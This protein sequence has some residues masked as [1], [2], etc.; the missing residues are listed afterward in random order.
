VNILM[1]YPKYPDQTFWNLD[2]VSKR[3]YGRRATMA[4]LGLLTIASYLPDDFVVRLVDRNIREE[5]DD[6]WTWADAVLIS[7]MLAQRQDCGTCL[8]NA[9]RHGVPVAVGGPYTS[10]H[11]DDIVA[12]ADWVCYGEAESVMEEFVADLRAGRRKRQYRGGN[13]TDTKTVRVP[14][15][16]LLEN[17]N[18][19]YVMPV[20]FS[21]GCPFQCEFCDIIEIYGR[22]PRVK[23]PQQILAELDAIFA[24]RFTGCVFI[25]DDNFIGNKKA[26][27][28]MLV[29]LAEWNRLHGLPYLY[30]TEASLNLAGDIRLLDAMARANFLFVFVGIETPDAALLTRAGKSQNTRADAL[31]QLQTIREHGI[32]VI[33]GMITGFDG[34][35]RD[36]F[37]KQLAFIEKSG[38]G[39]A[40]PG[41]LQAVPNTRLWR[42]L[43]RENRL[44]ESFS[45]SLNV[46]LEGLNFIPSGEM[47]KREYLESMGRMAVDMFRPEAFFRRIVPAHLALRKQI[48]P[49]LRWDYLLT[50]LRLCAALGFATKETRIPFW[51][52]LFTI[53]RRNPSALGAFCYDCMHYLH[54]FQHAAYIGQWV[55]DY[56]DHPHPDDVLDVAL[57]F[58][59]ESGTGVRAEDP[60]EAVG[61]PDLSSSRA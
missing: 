31:D 30:F 26:A 55:R 28:E 9:A 49:A 12:Q 20:Q 5:S 43:Q 2:K 19:Y 45:V 15:Y 8:G 60:P 59:L 41:L 23:T 54:L 42:R 52:A 18:D 11:P 47:T 29:S 50:L 37:R 56:L 6:D 33:A 24:L 4:P 36:V 22:V 25:V 57:P 39:I 7:A 13:T 58:E 44:L 46:T 14:R 61:I 17:V 34:E 27:R 10:A 48:R 51:K 35:T 21:R 38:V 32:H 16:D 53:L 3:I 1:L 40:I